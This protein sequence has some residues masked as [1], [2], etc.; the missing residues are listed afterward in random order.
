MLILNMNIYNNNQK[1]VAGCV[2]L[3][4]GL[5]FERHLWSKKTVTLFGHR[6]QVLSG[7]GGMF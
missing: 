2:V 3:D 6:I 4:D 5:V 1:S 7:C